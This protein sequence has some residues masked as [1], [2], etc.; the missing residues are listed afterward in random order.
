MTLL[1]S[2]AAGALA[3]LCF[4][5]ISAEADDGQIWIYVKQTYIPA[6]PKSQLADVS[7]DTLKEY[8]QRDMAKYPAIRDHYLREIEW[9][10]VHLKAVRT[11]TAIEVCCSSGGLFPSER[12]LVVAQ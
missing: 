11:P 8:I 5:F 1:L 12:R 4:Y 2:G 6:V 7:T 3:W 10:Q 9:R